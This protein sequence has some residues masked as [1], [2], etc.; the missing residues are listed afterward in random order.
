[1]SNLEHYFENLLFEGCDCGG[2]P[3]K[4]SLTRSEQKAVE[5]CANYVIYSLFCN[6]D[7]FLKWARGED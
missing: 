1:M 4:K 3:N 5:T 7:L 2:E 6:R